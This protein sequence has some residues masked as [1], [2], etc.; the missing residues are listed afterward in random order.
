MFK[1]ALE[2]SCFAEKPELSESIPFP[3]GNHTAFNFGCLEASA[4]SAWVASA[5]SPTA[6]KMQ[7]LES[8]FLGLFPHPALGTKISSE[9]LFA[10]HNF[11]SE[12]LDVYF[13]KK[14]MEVKQNK[15]ERP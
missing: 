2:S 8:S 4:A 9:S 15:A 3:F 13:G 6:K 14:Q 11:C 7:N 12:A 5:K 1:I 10:M